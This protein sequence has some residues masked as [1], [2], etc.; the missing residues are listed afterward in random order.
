MASNNVNQ[1]NNVNKANNV[2]RQILLFTRI[3]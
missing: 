2:I 1:T 3:P